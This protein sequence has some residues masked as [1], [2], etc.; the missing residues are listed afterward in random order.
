MG[1][2]DARIAAHKACVRRKYAKFQGM[3]IVGHR[4]LRAFVEA[5]LCEG[6]SPDSIAGRVRNHEKRLPSISADSIER[7]LKSVYGRKIEA[8]R[9][10]EKQKKRKKKRPQTHRLAGRKFI[11]IRPKIIE[12]RTRVGDAEA[13]FI[14]SGKDGKGCLLTIADRTLRVSF[15]EKILPVTIANVHRAFLRIKKRFSELRTITTDN[16]IL[17]LHHVELERL[18]KVKIYFCHPYHSWEKGTIENTNGVI[19]VDIPKGSSISSYTKRRIQKIEARLNDRYLACLEYR[20]PEEA[21]DQYRKQ[22]NAH[23]ARKKKQ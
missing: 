18:L 6:R 1:V 5:K 2:Y 23:D 3:K 10:L 13:D 16:D 4:A 15:V 14:V 20:T 9:R 22:K 21:L 19:R 12:K 11:D 8:K 7:F 17:F